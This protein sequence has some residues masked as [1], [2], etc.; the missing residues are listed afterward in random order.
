[1]IRIKKKKRNYISVL[2]ICSNHPN[3]FQIEMVALIVRQKHNKVFCSMAHLECCDCTM[4][5]FTAS[6]SPAGQKAFFFRLILPLLF[7]DASNSVKV[8]FHQVLLL[9]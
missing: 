2:F 4:A 6:A 1:M 8:Q 7:R 5:P 3:R 9:L